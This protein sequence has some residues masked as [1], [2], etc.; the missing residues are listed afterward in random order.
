MVAM[1]YLCPSR[2]GSSKEESHPALKKRMAQELLPLC[3]GLKFFLSKASPRYA[4]WIYSLW[5]K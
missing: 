2:Q 1:K 5:R 3:A 4:Q